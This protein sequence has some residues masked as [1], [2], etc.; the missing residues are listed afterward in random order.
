MHM[1]MQVCRFG[2]QA[3]AAAAAAAA[4]AAAAP[5]CMHVG[6]CSVCHTGPPGSGINYYTFRG[7]AAAVSAAAAA[8]APASAS[9]AKAALSYRALDR[10]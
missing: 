4:T 1:H 9:S 10:W 7:A 5:Q 6:P 2:Y 8:V 3:A